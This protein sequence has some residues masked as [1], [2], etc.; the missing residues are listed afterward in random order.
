MNVKNLAQGDFVIAGGYIAWYLGK[1][2]FT[3]CSVCR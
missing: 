2:A 3:P 1:F